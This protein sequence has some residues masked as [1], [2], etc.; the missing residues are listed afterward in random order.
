MVPIHS[1]R[2]TCNLISRSEIEYRIEVAVF[3][4]GHCR[5][6][7]LPPFFLPSANMFSRTC[8]PSWICEERNQEGDCLSTV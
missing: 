6:S 5:Q 1:F 2:Q 3:E 4:E 7:F 8:K